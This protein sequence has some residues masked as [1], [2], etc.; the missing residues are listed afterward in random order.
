MECAC[1]PQRAPLELR[2]K[3]GYPF[4]NPYVN[5]PQQSSQSLFFPLDKIT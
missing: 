5:V 2:P 1:R 3:K 4:S